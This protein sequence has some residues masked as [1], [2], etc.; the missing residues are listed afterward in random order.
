MRSTIVSTKQ[1]RRKNSCYLPS[2]SEE[3]FNNVVK[4]EK[5]GEAFEE[6]QNFFFFFFSTLYC[7]KLKRKRPSTVKEPYRNFYLTL[8][9]PCYCQSMKGHFS[10]KKYF[11]CFSCKGE[12]RLI[13]T[14]QVNLVSCLPEKWKQTKKVEVERKEEKGWNTL[15]PS[16]VLSRLLENWK[17]SCCRKDWKK[18]VFLL[19]VIWL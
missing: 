1:K 15:W 2:S 5:L 17:G 7:R 18:K 4:K 13:Y 8:T 10:V 11:S 14:Q 9:R 12:C 16:L 3:V 6:V 19:R